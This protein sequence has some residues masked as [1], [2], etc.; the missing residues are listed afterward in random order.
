MEE[1]FGRSQLHFFYSSQRFLTFPL[2][3]L[4]SSHSTPLHHNHRQYTLW[5]PPPLAPS[6]CVPPPSPVPSSP[7]SHNEAR[8]EFSDLRLTLMIPRA[9]VHESI[10]RILLE[11]CQLL[12]IIPFVD[13]TH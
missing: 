9:L 1:P 6:P 3:F 11:H 12:H 13:V 2:T 10:N 5:I 8:K 4:S 7:H